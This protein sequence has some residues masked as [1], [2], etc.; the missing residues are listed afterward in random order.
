MPVEALQEALLLPR[1][2]QDYG[3][4]AVLNHKAHVLEGKGNNTSLFSKFLDPNHTEGL[5]TEDIGIE[6]SNMIIAG[7][8]TTSVSLTYLIWVLLRPQNDSIKE[9][10]LREIQSLP[11]EA[12]TNNYTNSEYLKAVINE[13]LRLYGAA[14]GSLPRMVPESGLQCGRYYIPK[15]TTVST[16]AFSIHRD[17]S[18]FPDPE[19][20]ISLLQNFY[21]SQTD[22]S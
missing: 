13:T 7:P 16:Q 9:K 18:Y 17:P 12:R 2:L 11:S 20:S 1:R 8:D 5:T 19:K 15:G 3:T 14:P 10:V 22:R 21:N 4:K 6:A